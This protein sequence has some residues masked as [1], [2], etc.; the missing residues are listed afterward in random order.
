MYV[1]NKKILYSV[2]ELW[3]IPEHK[4]KHEAES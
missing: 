3:Q 1:S 2:L 4:Q